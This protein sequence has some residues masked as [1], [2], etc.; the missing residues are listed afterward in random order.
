M[1]TILPMTQ[2]MVPLYNQMD[3]RYLVGEMV[4]VRVNRSGFSLEYAPL[5]KAQWHTYPPEGLFAPQELL[6][7]PEAA[8]FFAF[9]GRE[10]VGQAVAARHGNNLAKVWDIRVD[11][12]SRRKSVGRTLLDACRN[13][14]VEQGLG[15]LILEIQD[16]NPGACQFAQS[17]GFLLGGVYRM[18][19]AAL[20]QQAQRPPALRDSALFFYRLFD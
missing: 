11:V 9:L 3:N 14:A 1:L 4:T 7:R 6:N 8:C 5:S 15:G 20:P 10:P 13:W 16:T 19:Y 12:R 2:D 18:L 17:C